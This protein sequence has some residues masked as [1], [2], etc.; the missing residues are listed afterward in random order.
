MYS[1][2]RRYR[3][4][5]SSKSYRNRLFA[6]SLLKANK[7][8]YYQMKGRIIQ[9]SP[10]NIA[11]TKTDVITRNYLDN[12]YQL[13]KDY[14]YPMA[15]NIDFSQYT[16]YFETL[17]ISLDQ[18]PNNA[19]L[20]NQFFQEIVE[21]STAARPPAPEG[22]HYD[23]D[24]INM[25]FHANQITSTDNSIF[26]LIWHSSLLTDGTLNLITKGSPLNSMS[27]KTS[28]IQCIVNEPQS[29]F[30]TTLSATYFPLLT[31]SYDDKK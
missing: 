5:Y 20:H 14:K 24:V 8:N 29:C 17:S 18:I 21:D 23:W 22:Y 12:A 13:L 19:E 7:P 11:D 6:P 1:P 2:R 16:Y 15:G 27:A 3:K 31:P 9:Q 4:Y 25:I 26:R 28:S 30:I 10:R